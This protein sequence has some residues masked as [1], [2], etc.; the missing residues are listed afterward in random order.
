MN[1]SLSELERMARQAGEVLRAGFGGQYRVDRKGAIDLVTE[2][3]HR[4]EALLLA[5]I[6][7][8][9]P[10]H[11]VVT[12]EQGVL[13]GDDRHVWYIDPLDGTVNFAHG[14]PI[15]T[16]SISFAKDGGQGH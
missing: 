16:V 3:D 15:F 13:A 8:R 4:S 7:G 1:P 2:M 14:V 10:D 9:Y 11:K 12:E 5:A 6:R